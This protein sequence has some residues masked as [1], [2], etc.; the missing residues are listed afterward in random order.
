MIRKY[1]RRGERDGGEFRQGVAWGKGKGKGKGRGI[2]IRKEQGE[3][4]FGCV[5]LGFFR[6]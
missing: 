6:F 4:S 3:M 5:G 1:R 2:Q